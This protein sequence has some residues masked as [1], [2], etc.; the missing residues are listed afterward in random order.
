MYINTFINKSPCYN[1]L[2]SR[3]KCMKMIGS[4][5]AVFLYEFKLLPWHLKASE[6]LHF[7]TSKRHLHT[8]KRKSFDLTA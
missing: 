5:R 7:V 2:L 4:M 8:R 6:R 3:L 1:F